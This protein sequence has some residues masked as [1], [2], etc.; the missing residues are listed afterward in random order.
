MAGLSP[1]SWPPLWRESRVPLEAAA[2]HADGVLSG[3]G[4][5][6]GEGAPVMLIPGFL[7]GDVS[8]GIMATWLRTLGYEVCTAGIR[9]NV[10]CST[11]AVERLAERLHRR[12]DDHGRPVLLVGQS[13]GGCLA[14]ILALQH[15]DEVAGVVTLGSPLKDMLAVHPLVRLNVLVVGALGTAGV[16]GLFSADCLWGDC[17]TDLRTLEQAPFPDAVGFLSVFSRT[18]GIVDWRACLDPAAEH[19]HVDATHCGMALHPAVYRAIAPRLAA[20]AAGAP[21]GEPPLSVAA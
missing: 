17:C 21:A 7:A 1:L 10:D 18:D 2:L 15:P 8:L 6:R 14:R 13:R 4:L 20:Y 12:A 11:R 19:V 5:P 16:G 9:A 3:D